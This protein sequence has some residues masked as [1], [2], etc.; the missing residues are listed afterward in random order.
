MYLITFNQQKVCLEPAKKFKRGPALLQRLR[1]S[2]CCILLLQQQH[3]SLLASVMPRLVHERRK[4]KQL[5]DPQMRAS[6]VGLLVG[7]LLALES[8]GYTAPHQG[9]RA[10]NRGCRGVRL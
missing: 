2:R 9:E 4:I 3:H 6:F 10:A 1:W 7:L 8:E 5:R